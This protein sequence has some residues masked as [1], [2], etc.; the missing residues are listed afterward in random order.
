VEKLLAALDAP[1]TQQP[2][3]EE[4]GAAETWRSANYAEAL[5][6]VT[7]RK[8]SQLSLKQ[9]ELFRSQFIG[10]HSAQAVFE[11]MFKSFHT[12]D[13]PELSVTVRSGVQEYGIRSISQDPFM[14]PWIGTDRPR[15]FYSCDVSR[16]IAALVDKRFPNRSRL[17]VDE[18]FRWQLASRVMDTIKHDWNLLDTENRIGKELAPVLALFTP[19]KSEIGNLSSIDLDGD[20]S[21]N[22]KLSSPEFPSNLVVGVSLRYHN[23]ELTGVDSLLAKAPQYARLVLSVPWLSKYMEKNPHTTVELRYVNG[24]SLSP[25]AL[26]NLRED[27]GKHNRRAQAEAVSQ[28]AAESAFLEIEDGS[29]CWSRAIVLPTREVLLWQFSCDSVLGFAAQSLTA[30]DYYSWRSTGTLID[31]YGAVVN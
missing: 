5:A 6:D 14:L 12:D 25:L 13:Y 1:V 30:W 2:S 10:S 19:M 15:G 27:L 29:G 9:I 22:A 3:L 31:P 4:C 26:K 20:Q 11:E 7:H 16:A 17:L 23:K 24:R 28:H 21:W 8:M 18:E